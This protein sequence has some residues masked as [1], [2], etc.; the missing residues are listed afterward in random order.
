MTLDQKIQIWNVVGTWLAG[1]ATFLAV[2]VS[3]YL[4]RKAEAVSIKAAVGVRLVFDGDG[5]PAEEYLAFDV[6][7]TGDRPVNIVSVG[8]SVG[9]RKNKRFCIQPVAGQYTHQYPKQLSHGEKASFLV[10]L[11]AVP[12]WSKEFACGF[13]RDTS[14][15]HLKTLRALVNTS[16]GKA[17]EVIPEKN[18]LERLRAA[19]V[20]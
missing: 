2:L 19:N 7:N 10:S 18:L 13:V 12:N 9:N 1:I 6:V 11:G 8:W 20:S 15:S 17:I 3:L 16:V 5:S 4:S 14:G